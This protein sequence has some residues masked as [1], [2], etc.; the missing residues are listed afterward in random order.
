MKSNECVDVEHGWIPS[1]TMAVFKNHWEVGH[2]SN[3]HNTSQRPMLK[4]IK[5]VLNLK[6]L[7]IHNRNFL[8][9]LKTL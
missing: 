8:K 4:A 7:K 1:Q 9:F 3:A 5:Q 6:N 2:F